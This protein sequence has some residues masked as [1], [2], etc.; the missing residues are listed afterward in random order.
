M[1]STVLS[2]LWAHMKCL[3]YYFVIPIYAQ[4]PE[5]CDAN[6]IFQKMVQ[7]DEVTHPRAHSKF[8]FHFPYKF[9]HLMVQQK[10]KEAK[11]I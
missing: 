4:V 5:P 8:R 10:Q 1:L 6:L 2:A 11:Y 3:L 7:K 9:I